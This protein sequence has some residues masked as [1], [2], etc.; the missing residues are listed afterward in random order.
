MLLIANKFLRFSSSCL[1]CIVLKLTSLQLG[2]ECSVSHRAPMP[3]NS[4]LIFPRFHRLKRVNLVYVYRLLSNGTF[5]WSNG[6]LLNPGYISLRNTN[7]A[8]DILQQ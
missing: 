6:A 2:A 4:T 7:V 8:F 1:R 3:V 5:Y